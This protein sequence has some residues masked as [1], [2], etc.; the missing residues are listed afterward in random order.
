MFILSHTFLA[1][2]Q[3]FFFEGG[4]YLHLEHTGAAISVDWDPTPFLLA[5]CVF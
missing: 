5:G 2:D 1:Q 3:A 4:A